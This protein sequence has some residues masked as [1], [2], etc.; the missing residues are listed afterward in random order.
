MNISLPYGER[1]LPADLSGVELLGAI[2]IKPA[3]S[4]KD[5]PGVLRAGLEKPIG[6]TQPF[7]TALKSG[8]TVAI[9][10]SDSFRK[11]GIHHVL[12]GLVEH[13]NTCG[14]A[15]EGMLFVYATGTH[16]GPT[17]EE[18]AVILGADICA[19]FQSQTLAHDPFDPDALVHIGDTSRG[20][21]VWMNKRV[22]ACDHVI[23]TGT[24]VLHYFAGYGGGRKAVVPGVAGVE[25][26]ARNHAMNL[27]PDDDRLDPAV[28]IGALGGNP[29]AEDMLEATRFL[30][31]A[32]LV[33]TVLNR[34]G[35][36]A[37]LFTGDIEIAH[38]AAVACA[39]DMYLA[40]ITQQADLVIATAGTAKNYIQS[41]KALYNAY[42]AMRPGGRIV[43]LTPSPEGYGGNKFR[44][45][46]SLGTPE[47]VISELRKNAEINGQTALSTL[48]KAPS[49]IFVTEMSREEVTRLGARK[50]ATLGDAITLAREEL[51][52]DGYTTPTTWIM[53]SASYSVPVLGHE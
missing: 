8:D 47:A 45:W 23:V 38:E 18:E 26:I 35:E 36:I 10:V 39:R 34:D 41:H 16:R 7:G 12:P 42:Q 24:V 46:V 50:A 43:F 17:P 52:A 53:P 48:Q 1:S 31:V 29:V 40:P 9:I 32:L 49:S 20:T 44:D 22:C 5:V 28:K 51:A 25:T 13:L 3:S 15:D 19:R 37:G 11:T 33:N 30:P 2:D 27:S 21:P 6:Q 14:I 4:L